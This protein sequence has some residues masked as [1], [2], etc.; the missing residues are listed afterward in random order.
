MKKMPFLFLVILFSIGL[1]SPPSV[2]AASDLTEQK[3]VELR[4]QLGNAKNEL[5]FFPDTLHFET[6]KL[7]RLILMNPS[8]QKHYFSSEAMSRAVFTRK[9]QI[10]GMDGKAIAEVKG[11]IREIEV[12]PQGTAEWWFVPVKAGTFRDLKCTITGHTER[13]MAGKVIIK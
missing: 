8:P 13:G 1:V 11:N 10:N 9:V 6:G 2:L 4:V 12:Y 5:R 7:Y 3:P